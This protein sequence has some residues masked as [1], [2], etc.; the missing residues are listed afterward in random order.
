MPHRAAAAADTGGA[1]NR[2]A[3]SGRPSRRRRRQRRIVLDGDLAAELAAELER[4]RRALTLRGAGRVAGLRRAERDRIV[5]LYR[6]A[7]GDEI[8]GPVG[9]LHVHVP[10][11][12]R[13]QLE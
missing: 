13:E 12:A 1:R 6:H 3:T 5:V 2:S 9:L 8:D 10:T 7:R 4:E 11:P